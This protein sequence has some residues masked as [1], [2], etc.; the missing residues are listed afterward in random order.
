MK[1][2]SILNDPKAS[3]IYPIRAL[4]EST[5]AFYAIARSIRLNPSSLKD[6]SFGENLLIAIISDFSR[7]KPI[8][9]NLESKLDWSTYGALELLE[10]LEAAGAD[11][12]S[13]RRLCSLMEERGFNAVYKSAEQTPLSDRTKSLWSILPPED[14]D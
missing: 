11:I 1:L 9:T 8:F 12:A 4:P 14:R 2:F 13:A 6:Q 7:E 5:K 3:K 10:L